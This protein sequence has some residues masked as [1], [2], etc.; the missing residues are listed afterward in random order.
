MMNFDGSDNA[1]RSN[2]QHGQHLDLV[3]C[4]DQ[5][6]GHYYGPLAAVLHGLFEPLTGLYVASH[7][8]RVL[9]FDPLQIFRRSVPLMPNSGKRVSKHLFHA[10]RMINFIRS[11]PHVPFRYI[12]LEA[13]KC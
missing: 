1:S 5:S 2:I 6:L 3:W 4:Q 11:T 10:R 9:T 7:C 8:P 13:V 12:V